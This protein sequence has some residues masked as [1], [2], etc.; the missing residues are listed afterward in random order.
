M[1]LFDVEPVRRQPLPGEDPAKIEA[2]LLSA[3][4]PDLPFEV[5][6]DLSPTGPIVE[7]KFTGQTVEYFRLWIICSLLSVLSLSLYR[8]W[9]KLRIR[10]YLA[11]HWYLNGAH[12]EVQYDPWVN[13]RGR[14]LVILTAVAGVVLAYALPRLQPLLIILTFS[15]APWLMTQSNRF[16]WQ[17]LSLKTPQTVLHLGFFGRSSLLY[18][19][20]MLLFQF[21]LK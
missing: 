11:S 12:F 21:P 13:L 6:P 7:L 16:N 19:P 14:L 9:A 15:A 18:K 4:Q 2:E 5:D 1:G 3:E 8:P 17:S 10:R 20:L